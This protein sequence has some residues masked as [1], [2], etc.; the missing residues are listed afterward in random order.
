MNIGK[1]PLTNAELVKAMFLSRSNKNIDKAKQD[2]IALQWDNIEKELHNDS[3]WYFLTNEKTSAKYQT[4]IDLVLD[5]V[6][7]KKSNNQRNKYATFFYFNELRETQD[8]NKIWQDEIVQTFL[9]LKDWYEDHDFYHKIG[10]LITSEVKS[11]FDIYRESK[12]KTKKDFSEILDKSI[13]SGIKPKDGESYSDWNYEEYR[14]NIFKLLLLF[15]VESVR[16]NGENSQWFPFDKFKLNV[17]SLER[18]HAVNS[19][20]GTQKMWREWLELHRNSL[21]SLPEDNSYLIAEID[22]L[23]KLK[24]IT[25]D[26]FELLQEK[27]IEKFT[28]QNEIED[29]IHSIENLALLKCETN[30]AL[31]NSTFDVKR[32]AIIEMDKHGEFIPFCTKMLFLKY[33]TRS[34]KNQ[35][36]F[37]S[38]DDRKAYIAEI[39]RVLEN[40]L[41][42]PIKYSREEV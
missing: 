15:N 42:E 5:L 18:V 40:Y 8:L 32:N 16:Q 10:Y 9:L 13:K 28:P 30:S 38:Q 4:R 20:K 1:I 14:E 7:G 33:Y 17:W 12:G 31:S 11:L 23:L 27:I 6:A 3:F 25:S 21:E 26:K 2:E 39:N 41:S 29:Y 36:H 19:K 22:E 24:N 37:W 34:E 35:I